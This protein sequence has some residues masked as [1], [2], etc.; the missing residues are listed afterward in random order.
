MLKNKLFAILAIAIILMASC[1]QKP[2]L[3]AELSAKLSELQG[4]VDMKAADA[5][6]FAPATADSVLQINGQIQ[7]GE[8]GHVRLD[9]SSGTIIRVAPSSMFTLTSNDPTDQGLITK[10]TLSAGKLFVILKGGSTD[11]ETPSGVASVRGSYMKVEVDPVTGDVYVTCLEGHCAVQNPAGTVEFTTGQRTTLFHK[12][13]NGNWTVPGVEDMSQ[14]EFQEWLDNNPEAKELF[15]Q[16]METATALAQPSSTPTSTPEAAKSADTSPKVCKIVQP[17]A[18]SVLPA[19]GKVNY[20]WE[21]QDG[22]Q[23]YVIT[24]T[25]TNGKSFSFETTKTNLEKYVEIMPDPGDYQW[26]VKAYAA[27]GSELCASGAVT[28]SKPDSKWVNPNKK[29]EPTGVPACDSSPS[30]SINCCYPF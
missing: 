10:I 24:F 27:D 3:S 20:E 29:E 16:A 25:N 18:G 14:E 26:E 23:K 17:V 19:Q 30:C 11:V 9:L 15:D 1:Q 28:F 8:D 4:K 13:A 2:A 22:A 21:P 12:D 7:T 5:S 6:A